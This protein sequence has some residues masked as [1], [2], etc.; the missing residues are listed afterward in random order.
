MDEEMELLRQI[1]ETNKAILAETRAQNLGIAALGGYY[2]G[3]KVGKKVTDNSLILLLF[4][5]IIAAVIML[6]IFLI[7]LAPFIAYGFAVLYAIGEPKWRHRHRQALILSTALMAEFLAAVA[8]ANSIYANSIY[9]NVV[10]FLFLIT[11]G[12]SIIFLISRA[13]KMGTKKKSKRK[14]RSKRVTAKG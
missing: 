4:L 8:L 12:Y 9:A 6:V 2:V 7:M 14:S 3:N 5:F 10:V 11:G 1:N 13:I